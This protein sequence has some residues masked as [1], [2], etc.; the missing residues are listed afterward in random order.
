MCI[1]VG[2][3]PLLKNIRTGPIDPA[4][5]DNVKSRK[6]RTGKNQVLVVSVSAYGSLKNPAHAPVVLR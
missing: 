1:D 4:T 5:P 3:V 2:D 6:S